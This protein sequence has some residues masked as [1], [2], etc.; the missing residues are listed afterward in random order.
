[1]ELYAVTVC[2]YRYYF[3]GALTDEA[4]AAVDSFCRHMG[5][6]AEREAPQMLFSRLMD[7]ITSELKC[8]VLPLGIRRVF[9]IGR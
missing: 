1:M 3:L 8:P 9:R 7:Y 2:G 6:G 4:S 5:V